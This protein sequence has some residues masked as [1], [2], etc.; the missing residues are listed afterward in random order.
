MKDNFT[1]IN[2]QK[3]SGKAVMMLT[4]MVSFY[5]G[6]QSFSASKFIKDFNTLKET[7]NHIHVDIV[8]LYGGSITEGIP[9]YNHIRETAEAGEVKI[10]GKIDGLAASMGSIIAMGIPVDE[11]EMGNMARIMNH[12]AKGGAWGTADEVKHAGENIASY[13]D[14]L[15]EILSERTGLSTDDIRSKWMDGKDHY[16]KAA[17][18]KKLGLVGKTTKSKAIKKAPKNNVDPEAVFNFYQQQI[19]NAI[20]I[21]IEPIE[22]QNEDMKLIAQ[23]IAAFAIAGIELNAENATE[24]SILGQVK[25]LAQNNKKLTDDLTEAKDKLSKQHKEAVK[26]LVADAKKRDLIKENQEA[27]LT[28][29]ANNNLDDARE[30]VNGLTPHKPLNERLNSGKGDP[31]NENTDDEKDFDWYRKNDHQAL[32]KMKVNDPENYKALKDAHLAKNN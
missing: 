6:D 31:K 30:F 15:V 22:N 11:L 28:K 4:G 13:E 10:T 27:S 5:N 16:I 14:D 25:T 29:M 21:D 8:N 12:R 9:V 17:E 26:N 20:D 7:H 2:K 23:F 24:E 18:A 19:V 1:V 3:N 32:Q